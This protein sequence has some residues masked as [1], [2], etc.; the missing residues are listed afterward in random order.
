MVWH[1][2]S[3]VMSQGDLLLAE[4]EGR[5]V[6]LGIGCDADGRPT[7][8][9]SAILDG[10]VLL[11]YGSNKGASIAVMVE[12]FAA[13]LTGSPFGF[14]D[15][16]PSAGGTTS[17]GGQF[18][19]LIDPKRNNLDFGDRVNGLMN[20]FVGAGAQRL[21]VDR[22]YRDRQSAIRDG[23]RLA[24]SQFESLLELAGGAQV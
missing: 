5:S 23:V 6:S 9:P 19:L 3:S 11:P 22:R 14:E 16:S 20:A 12:I 21:P 2:S 8:S 15:A 18:L 4:K 1:Q 10:G 24:R 7:T 13:A 17:K